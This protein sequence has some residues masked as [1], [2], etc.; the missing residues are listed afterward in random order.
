MFHTIGRWWRKNAPTREQL[1]EVRWLRPFAHRVLEPS[2]WRFTRRSVPRG[3]AL[4]LIVGIFLMIPGLQIIGA[5]LLA[6]PCRANVPIAVAMTFLSNPA[7]TPFLLYLSIIVGNRF[8]HS[9]ADVSTVAVMIEHG[10]SLAE[11]AGWLMSSAAPA[12][13]MGL[14]V[15]SVISASVGYLLSSCSWRAWISH[16][17]KLRERHRAEGEAEEELRG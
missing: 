13:V 10:A 2:L 8:I 6:L 4:G 5:A 11:W 12:L 15:I 9:T 14:F 17:W 7:T 16:K 3:V 1:E